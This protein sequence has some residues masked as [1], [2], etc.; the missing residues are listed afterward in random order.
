MGAEEVQQRGLVEALSGWMVGKRT[1]FLSRFKLF[2]GLDS[3][4]LA[5]AR[6]SEDLLVGKS[7]LV[8]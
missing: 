3:I 4:Q 5:F 2:K 1:I 7:P 8:V 6:G